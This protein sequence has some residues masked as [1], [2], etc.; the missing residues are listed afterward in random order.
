MQIRKSQFISIFLLFFCFQT[1]ILAQDNSA[2]LAK[3][4]ILTFFDETGSSDFAYLPDSLAKVMR[5]SMAQKFEFA[6]IDSQY[7]DSMAQ[8]AR[9][10]GSFGDAT[11]LAALAKS[12]QADIIMFGYLKFDQGDQKIIL[13]PRIY[14]NETQTIL[15]LEPVKNPVD[16]SIFSAVD[17]A[18]QIAV[19]EITRIALE[20]RYENET[21]SETEKMAIRRALLSPWEEKKWNLSMTIGPMFFTGELENVLEPSPQLNLIASYTLF[22]NFFAAGT[23]MFHR[24][25][26]KNVSGSVNVTSEMNSSALLLGAGYYWYFFENMRLAPSISAGY[27]YAD[28]KDTYSAA[29]YSNTFSIYNPIAETGLSFDYRLPWFDGR[30]YAGLRIFYTMIFDGGDNFPRGPGLQINLGWSF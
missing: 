1:I 4:A 12:L 3:V 28:I 8:A 5:K 16:D 20:N 27:Y 13:D 23:I 11:S 19:D 2:N 7:S 18:S 26:N 22:D 21:I 30:F 25:K 17:K 29:N 6:P 10:K 14:L 9:S 15:E 24:L